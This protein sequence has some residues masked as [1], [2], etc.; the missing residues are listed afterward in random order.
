MATTLMA[1]PLEVQTPHPELSAFMISAAQLSTL[2]ASPVATPA[3]C[4]PSGFLR[5]GLGLSGPLS[6][7]SSHY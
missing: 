2:H 4:T 1:C 3:T 7:S 6:G 5:Q